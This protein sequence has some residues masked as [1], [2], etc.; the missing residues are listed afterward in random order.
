ML[1]MYFAPGFE[2]TEAVASLDVIRR[3][4]IDIRTVGVGSKQV[5]G[6]HNITVVC[7]MDTEEA[8]F[9]GLD[10]I[11]LPGGMPG[12][13]NL[14]ESERVN[15]AI[16]FFSANGK[17]LAAI[18]AAPMIYGKRGLLSGKSAVCYPGFEEYLKG[19]S[20]PDKYVVTDGNVITAKGMGS[21]VEFGL[22]I[23]AYYKGADAA[24]G[25]RNTLECYR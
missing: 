12:T 14:D 8:T 25:L 10:G 17:L 4:G 11:I 20:V 21:A 1:Y 22:A 3:A 24:D 19:A 9:T 6:S 13:V 7:D 16:E 23:A 15:E 2:E 18:C 5:T